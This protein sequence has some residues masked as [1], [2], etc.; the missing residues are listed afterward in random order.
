MSAIVVTGAS[1]F[2]GLPMIAELARN[3]EEVHAL[4]TRSSPPEITGVRWHQVD[5][6][7][8]D[9]TSSVIARLAP[10]RLVHLAWYVEHGLFWNA[11]E[12]VMWVE[13]SLGMLRA[14][15]RAGGV[16]ALML[17]TCA[18]YDWSAADGPLSETQTPI[19]PATLY[20]V[21]K[22]ALRRVASAYAEREGLELAWGRPF[23]FYGPRESPKRLVSSVI[24]A[25]LAGEPVDTTSGEQRRDFLHV[26]DVAGALVALLASSAVGPVNIGSGEGVAVGDVIDALAKTV[27]GP[28]L[29][30]RGALPDRPEPWLLVADVTRLREEVGYRPRWNLADGLANTV[31]WWREQLGAAPYARD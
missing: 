28:D 16:R 9:A 7:D 20:G 2:I 13:R 4:S 24:R 8:E 18:E 29:V 15:T 30:R 19:A 26:D 11:P 12:N 1:G 14:F 22:D 10:E 17:G 5:L 23:F 3:G 31:G 25:L 27:G 6:S 21:S